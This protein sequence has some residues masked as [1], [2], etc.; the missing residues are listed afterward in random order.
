MYNTYYI[1]YIYIYIYVHI[2]IYEISALCISWSTYLTSPIDVDCA[3]SSLFLVRY[4]GFKCSATHRVLK[5]HRC[6]NINIS[7]TLICITFIL[8]H[9]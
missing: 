4:C 8:M 7:N 5:S 2:Y 3:T 6:F 1:I 9:L